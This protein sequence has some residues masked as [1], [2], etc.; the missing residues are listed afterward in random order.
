MKNIIIVGIVIIILIVGLI[1][2]FDNN[3]ENKKTQNNI[4]PIGYKLVWNDEFDTNMDKWKLISENWENAPVDNGS[5]LLTAYYRPIQNYISRS[6]VESKYSFQYGYIEFRGRLSY[7]YGV[8]NDL[9]LMPADGE[10]SPEMDIL[11]RPGKVDWCLHSLMYNNGIWDSNYPNSQKCTT[12]DGQYH[13]FGMLW[14]P[15]KIVFYVDGVERWRAQQSWLSHF[16][17]PMNIDMALCSDINVGCKY[18]GLGDATDPNDLPTDFAIDYVRV[19]QK[20]SNIESIFE[21]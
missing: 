3:Y 8:A 7:V 12:S 19:Y 13:I 16:N 4:V 1:I 5:V 20:H 2:V 14:E 17:V 18:Q 9:W 21:T 11:E 6:S 10:L 15:D